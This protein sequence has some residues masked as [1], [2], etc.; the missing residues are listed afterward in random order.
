[1]HLGQ[2]QIHEPVLAIS[3]SPL[4]Y[5]VWPHL[6]YG[7][8]SMT[9]LTFLPVIRQI[10]SKAF[11]SN[12]KHWPISGGRRQYRLFLSA[13]R[14]TRSQSICIRTQRYQHD[15]LL[16]I[17]NAQ[18]NDFIVSNISQGIHSYTFLHGVFFLMRRSCPFCWSEE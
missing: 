6:T 4:I 11:T 2:N 13:G 1:M 12:P 7:H 10:I 16:Q 17:A 9:S 15:L 3:Q 5:D 14:I 18:W 8:A